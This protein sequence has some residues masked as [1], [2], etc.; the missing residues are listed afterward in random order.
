MSSVACFSVFVRSVSVQLNRS[1]NL[2]RFFVLSCGLSFSFSL[3]SI[4]SLKNCVCIGVCV[5]HEFD[6]IFRCWEPENLVLPLGFNRS[7]MFEQVGNQ[8][9]IALRNHSEDCH[10]YW[11]G[12]LGFLRRD[13]GEL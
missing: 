10:I 11:F 2:V 13:Y 4:N 5:I 3:S 6:R 7:E 1:G 8:L 12:V 9:R